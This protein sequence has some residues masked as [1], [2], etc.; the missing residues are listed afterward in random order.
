ST[1]FGNVTDA[2]LLYAM[3]L[4][5]DGKVLATG[6][7]SQGHPPY[8]HASDFPLVRYNADGSLDPAFGQGGIAFLP[9]P[10]GGRAVAVQRDG[11]ILVAVA[12]SEF[13]LIRATSTGALDPTFGT[14]GQV[15]TNIGGEDI[16]D[17]IA[18]QSD[19]KILLA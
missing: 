4:Q 10:N 16:A 5:P 6:Y 11:K 2:V 8:T 18:L 19:G 14:G 15:V 9:G 7:A 13:T 17:A 1:S 3:T 12:G